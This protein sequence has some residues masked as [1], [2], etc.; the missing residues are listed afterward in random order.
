MGKAPVRLSL[1]DRL[2]TF[3]RSICVLQLVE[4]KINLIKARPIVDRIV[5]VVVVVSIEHGAR[6]RKITISSL[7]SPHHLRTEKINTARDEMSRWCIDTSGE[8]EH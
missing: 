1:V 7:V 5:F 8:N 3:A 2:L 4:H 6:D